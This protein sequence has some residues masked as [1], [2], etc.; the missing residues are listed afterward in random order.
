MVAALC[1]SAGSGPKLVPH[2]GRNL[3]HHR[4]APPVAQARKSASKNIGNFGGGGDRFGQFGD[5]AHIQYRVEI[6][7]NV[8]NTPGISPRQNQQRNRLAIGLGNPAK[9]ILRAGSVLHREHADPAPTA[10][11]RNRV[12][13]VQSRSLLAHDYRTDAGRGGVLEDVIDRVARHDLDS[14]APEDLGNRITSFHGVFLLA[15]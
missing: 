10:E 6:R 9:G 13:H 7:G 4:T 15:G 5:V 2:L 12:G 8:R 11:A 1:T 14:F 3:D